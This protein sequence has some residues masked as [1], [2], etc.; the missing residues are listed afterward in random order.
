MQNVSAQ[1]PDTANKTVVAGPQYNRSRLHHFLWGSHYRK[2]WSTPVTIKVFYLDTANGGLTAYDKGGS[3]QTMS[4]R[5][6]DGQKRE[7]VLR[8]IDKSFTNALPE[9]YRGTFVQSIIN[10]QVSIAH[11]FAAV[12]VAPLA[13][14]AGIYHTWPQN[15]FVPQQ[16][17]L[18]QF[19]NK[20]GNKLYLFE[21]RPDGNWETADNFGDAEKI[22]G[23]DKLFK[24]LAK[25]NDRTVDQVEYVRARLFDMFVGDWGRHEDQWR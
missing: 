5:L 23:T 3:R 21:Q 13:E 8:S 10:D 24:K 6:H 18:G 9:L 25:D 20:Y 16:P 7:Y 14:K 4:L 12:V 19:S 17:S 22:I 11:P 2:E 15:V 1:L